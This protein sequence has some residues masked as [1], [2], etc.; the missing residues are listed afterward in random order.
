[1]LGDGANDSLAFDRALCRGTPAIH[2]G[3]L[4]QKADFYY[5]GRGIGGIRA[6]FEV[7]ERRRQTQV[8]LLAFMIAYNVIA[9]GL[10]AAGWMSPLLAAVLM[11]LSSLT[12]LTIVGLGL[13]RAGERKD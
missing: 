5:L 1:M 10:A 11:P 8:A 7:N 4:E 2:R 12:T 13:W 9:V 3:A 6:L